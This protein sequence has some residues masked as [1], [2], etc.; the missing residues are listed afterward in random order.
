MAKWTCPICD[1]SFGRKGQSHVC[2]PTEP[3]DEY[4]ARWSDNDRQIAGLVIDAVDSCGPVD[5]EA[6]QVGLFFKTTRT[7]IQLRPKPK[8]LELM[9]VVARRVETAR[10]RRT[11]AFGGMFAIFTDLLVVDDVDDWIHELIF[12]AYDLHPDEEAA[13]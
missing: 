8:R 5:V 6:A 7:I 1:R 9:L 2:E 11:I 13:G 3:L 10:V 12:E 4:L